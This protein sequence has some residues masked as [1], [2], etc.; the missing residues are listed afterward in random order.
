MIRAPVSAS[1]PTVGGRGGSAGRRDGGGG[2]PAAAGLTV[3]RVV[4]PAPN[5][6]S[7]FVWSGPPAAAATRNGKRQRCQR[8][9]TRTPA[10]GPEK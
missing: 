1:G 2:G 8:P 5:C 6:P 7:M 4:R 9:G 3:R 10:R